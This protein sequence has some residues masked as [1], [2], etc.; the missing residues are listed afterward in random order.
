MRILL[1]LTIAAAALLGGCGDSA[2]APAVKFRHVESWRAV[3]HVPTMRVAERACDA[4]QRGEY[5]ARLRR[6]EQIEF[7]VRGSRGRDLTCM[8]AH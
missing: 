7:R 2:A 1:T 5:G 8:I 6:I 3:A 4:A